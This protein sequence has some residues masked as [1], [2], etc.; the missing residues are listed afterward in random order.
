MRKKAVALIIVFILMVTAI[1]TLLV[2]FGSANPYQERG[3]VPPDSATHP[4]KVTVFSPLNNSAYTTIPLTLSVNVTLPESSTASGTILYYV[5]CRSDWQENLTYLYINTGYDN[6]VE[7]QIPGAKHQY[8]QGSQN[9][10]DIPDGN[11]T[12]T[13]TAIAGG[14][15]PADNLGFYRFM[16]NGSSTVYFV[17][18][19]QPPK[20]SVLTIKNETYAISDLALNFTVNE[21]TSEL[22]Y[23]LDGAANVT[24]DG[25]VTL[26]GLLSGVHNITVFAQDLSGHIGVSKT[27]IFT[28]AL[29]FPTEFVSAASVAAVALVA[30]GL[31]VYHKK[32]KRRMNHE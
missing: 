14:F 22:M 8:F 15:Y 27:I 4:P 24:I 13:I 31:L 25:N 11:H 7:S 3:S 16:I 17:I 28:I 9:L 20:I 2:N 5:T 10:T 30:A 26:R 23:S 29:P 32:H 12:I 18:D 1:G 21:Q 19:S 6:S